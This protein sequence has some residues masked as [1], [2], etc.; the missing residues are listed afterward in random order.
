MADEE[1]CEICLLFQRG[2]KKASEV[3]FTVPVKG[4]GGMRGLLFRILL[5]L[6]VVLV[7]RSS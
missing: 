6:R 5:Q 3:N 2:G 4:L 1:S 7:A